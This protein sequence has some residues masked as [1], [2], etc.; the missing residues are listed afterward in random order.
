MMRSLYSA[1]SGLKSH[2]TKMDAVGHNIANV[3]T[4]GYKT[5]RVTFADTLYQTSSGAAA[6]RDNRG[7]VNAKQIGLGVGVSAVDTIFTDSSKQA[8]GKNTDVALSGNGLFVVKD[9]SGTYYTRDG[10]FAFDADGNYVTSGG[11]FV[12]GWMADDK[13]KLSTTGTAGKIT[14]QSGKS[15]EPTATSTGTYTNNVNS[16][17]QGGPVSSIMVSYTDGTSESVTNYAPVKEE[18]VLHTAGGVSV[19][20]TTGTHT[21]GSPVGTVSVGTI[22]SV[23]AAN[24]GEVELKV[25]KATS[26][27]IDMVPPSLTM[28]NETGT[29]TYPGNFEVTKQIVTVTTDA[30]AKTVT[31]TFAAGTDGITSVTIPKPPS[32]TYAAGDDFKISVPL[33]S[34]KAKT[35]AKV[36]VRNGTDAPVE[37]TVGTTPGTVAEAEVGKPA[38]YDGSSDNITSIERRPART[39]MFNGKVPST[40]TVSLTDGTTYSANINQSYK[41]GTNYYPPI[42]TTITVY[43]TLGNA[44]SVP[45]LVGMKEKDSTNGNKWVASLATNVLDNGDTTLAMQDVEIQFDLFGKVNAAKT[46]PGQLTLTYKNGADSS[47]GTQIVS[48]DFSSLTQYA[49][50]NTIKS[51]TNG[52]AAGTLQSLSIDSAG[53][54]SGTYSNG[55]I[56]NEAQIAVAQFNNA[57]GLT[58]VGGNYYQVSNNSGEANVRSATDLGVTFS[59]GQLEMSGTDIA[60]EFTEMITTQRGFQ[61]NSKIITVDDEMLETVINMKR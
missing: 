38:M 21:V 42:S 22:Q 7:G 45:I 16:N 41:T 57:A 61:S 51:D 10:S 1:V 29:F 60:N 37:Y 9:N 44:H 54:I 25:S 19:P 49:G 55:I 17:P 18:I 6:P 40:V 26:G 30:V 5:Q 20:V 33:D 27:Y 39:P 59:P 52:N 11:Q 24:A 8:T 50:G 47:K 43:D 12:Q 56:K 13:G 4:Y 48:V 3:N 36:S 23:T 2:Q 32:G 28:A 35:G 58:R 46:Q 14:V 31:L 34:V 53:V 15:M